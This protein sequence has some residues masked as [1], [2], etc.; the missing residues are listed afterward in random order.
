MHVEPPT[1]APTNLKELAVHYVMIVLGILTA[2]GLEAGFEAL[3][4]RKLARQTIEQVEVELK[5][6]LAEARETLKR[7]RESLQQL[8][9]VYAEAK[10]LMDQGR[11]KPA[12]L[13]TLLSE[14][15]RISV[16]MPGLRRDAWDTALADQA[17]MH[18]PLPDL[19]RLSEAYAVQRDA[20]QSFQMTFGSISSFSRLTDAAVDAEFGRGDPVDLIKALHAYRLALNAVIGVERELEKQ[21]MQSLGQAAAPAAPSH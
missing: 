17:L 11:A 15:L 14:K 20:Q 9:G 18:L 16:S 1:H 4:H 13:N 21:L 5:A 3:H 12:A 2:L 7:N 8:D 10:K 19:R 6:N